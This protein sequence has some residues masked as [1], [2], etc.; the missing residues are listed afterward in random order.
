MTRAMS[1]GSLRLIPFASAAGVIAVVAGTWAIS[2]IWSDPSSPLDLT[3]TALGAVGVLGGVPLAAWPWLVRAGVVVDPGK[4]WA[5]ALAR[6]AAEHG[7]LVNTDPE[8][9]VWFDTIHGG[10]RFRVLLEPLRQRLR[11]TSRQSA[12]HG[13]VVTRRGQPPEDH[14]SEWAKVTSGAE[15]SMR[16]A[17]RIT[18]IPL[19]ESPRLIR[20]L[21]EFFAFPNA[22]SVSFDPHGISLV[23]DLPHP[24]RAARV[25]RAAMD[26]AWAVWEAASG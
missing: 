10:P 14:R 23:L 21:D 13:V 11:L 25:V 19:V 8:I 1:Q 22:R 24:E 3:R 6:I 9:G 16:A 26:A 12:R 18:A 5:D 2:P 17:V 15:W 4:P 20:A 7:Q